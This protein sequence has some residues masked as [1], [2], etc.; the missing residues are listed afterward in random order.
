MNHFSAARQH[1]Q[2]IFHQS[3]ILLESGF[4]ASQIQTVDCKIK[5]LR[6]DIQDL[7]TKIHMVEKREKK[8]IQPPARLR[9]PPTI[10]FNIYQHWQTPAQQQHPQQ[11]DAQPMHIETHHHHGINLIPCQTT[12]FRTGTEK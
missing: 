3:C 7:L 11:Q 10:E 2:S 8:I 6:N 4:S 12:S 5:T 1:I 9:N